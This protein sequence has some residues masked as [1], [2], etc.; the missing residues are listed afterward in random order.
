MSTINVFYLSPDVTSLPGGFMLWF[1][2][3]TELI[4]DLGRGENSGVPSNSQSARADFFFLTK[5]AKNRL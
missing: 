4:Q 2:F 3:F 5:S 1:E